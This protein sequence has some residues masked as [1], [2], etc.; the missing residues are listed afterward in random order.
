MAVGGSCTCYSFNLLSLS[1]LPRFTAQHRSIISFYGNNFLIWFMMID[2]VNEMNNLKLVF[3]FVAAPPNRV[4]SEKKEKPHALNWMVSLT[5]VI[6]LIVY[7][8]LFFWGRSGSISRRDFVTTNNTNLALELQIFGD[9]SRKP[10]F[11]RKTRNGW[12]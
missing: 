5:T 6:I 4:E 1:P 10:L 8:C 11:N 12:A 7:F 9:D 2:L 3:S